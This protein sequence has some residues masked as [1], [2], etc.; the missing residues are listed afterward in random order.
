MNATQQTPFLIAMKGH[1]ATGKSLVARG[2]V[3]LLGWPIIDKD[4]IK[5]HTL[6]VAGGNV[7]AYSIMWQI[8]E[9][10]LGLGVSVIADSPLSYPIGYETAQ[11]LA[12][13]YNARLFVVE[14]ILDDALWRRRLDERSPTESSHKIRGWEAMQKQLALY[15]DCWRYAIN[16][17]HHIL[18]DTA[19]PVERLITLARQ[20]IL[21][22][23]A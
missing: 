2:L 9:T 7:L 10:Q 11:S 8:V 19:Q 22:E 23:G 16:P 17:A 6:A 5:D 14:T 3:R 4:D 21:G 1:P 18:V 13:R 20:R 12:A 15:D